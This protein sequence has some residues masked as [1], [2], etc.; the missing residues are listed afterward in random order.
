MDP[1]Y[2]IG[3]I[4]SEVSLSLK[5]KKKK[6]NRIS[7]AANFAWRL[8][9]ANAYLVINAS[10][11]YT[12]KNEKDTQRER[13]RERERERFF[14]IAVNNTQNTLNIA[15]KNDKLSLVGIYS[16]S[17]VRDINITT[18]RYFLITTKQPGRYYRGMKYITLFFFFNFAPYLRI[19]L[20]GPK[21]TVGKGIV[22]SLT[23]G[24]HTG[25][26]HIDCVYRPNI[27]CWIYNAVLTLKRQ[28]QLQ[29]TTF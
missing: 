22:L 6:K 8:L 4:R 9:K 27:S 1:I 10:A 16:N 7:S 2:I 13:E 23:N 29:Q 11:P 12:K 25:S 17:V 26:I 18:L 20:C 15:H 28:S 24:K 3:I 19:F 21:P 5:K 14:Y